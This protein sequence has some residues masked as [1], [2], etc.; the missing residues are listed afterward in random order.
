M[1]YD[2]FL[3]AP[4]NTGLQTDLRPWLIPDDA[5]QTLTNM[6]IF[7]GRLRKRFGSELMVGNTV[8][9][10]GTAQLYSRARLSVGTTNAS[11]NLSGTVPG[12][13]SVY[14]QIG[15]M[16][17][18]GNAIYTVNETGIA[19]PMLQTISTTTAT[20]D[21]TSGAFVFA[22]APASTTVYYYPAQPIMGIGQYLQG[23]FLSE[24]TYV[25]DTQFAYTWTGNGWAQLGAGSW[26]ITT[27]SNFQFFW[28]TTWRG[29]QTTS[30]IPLFFITNFNAPDKMQVWNGTTWTIFNP[31]Y[32][33][34]S[35]DNIITCRIILP[36]KGRLLLLNT[37]ESLSGTNTN[38]VNRCRFSAVGDPTATNAFRD[39]IPGNGGFV[40]AS[41]Y[42]QIVSAQI[43]KDRLIVFFEASTWELVYTNNQIVPFVWQKI[44]TELGSE[45][46]FSTIP[47]DKVALTVGNVGIH[48]CNGANVERIDEKIPDEVFDIHN[49]QDGPF[50]VYGIR[51]FETEMAYWTFPESTQQRDESNDE[52]VFPNRI[53]VYNYRTG[54]W[55]FN[56]DCITAFGYFLEQDLPD[57]LTWQLATNQWQE[58]DETWQ[59]G[60]LEAQT[61]RI[62]A[63]NQ[64]GF[65][66]LIDPDN[67]RN[68][69]AMQITNMI[70]NASVSSVTLTVINHNLADTDISQGTPY[71]I[72]IENCSGF[73]NLN[74]QIFAATMVADTNTFSIV[75]PA[76]I[77]PTGAY[78]GGGTIAIVSN[79]NIWSKQWN[80]YIDQGMNFYL[81]K[82]D[83]GVQR[84]EDGAV[85]V[86]YYPSS[87]TLSMLTEGTS[88]NT[89]MGTG[90]L[91]TSPYDPTIYPFEQVQDRLWHSVYFQTTGNSVQIRIYMSDSQMRDPDTTWNP[92]TI[93][94]L[95]LY[96]QPEGRLQ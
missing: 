46:T 36:F 63:G 81:A 96:T 86:D 56:S 32:D 3:I 22:G 85:T 15:Q 16:F 60:Y 48:A 82:I 71:Y 79:V 24:P 45:S 2:R 14:S 19:M 59:S 18:I 58:Y 17:S 13:S 73:T 9:A 40:D 54:A 5:F 28:T 95:V 7:R 92:F 90:V 11:G 61:V 23:S 1:P 33:G 94:G 76:P 35:G 74:G 84:T 55:A 89:I 10:T 47:F 6:Y 44:N 8:P 42:E 91:E 25:F 70:Y 37:V 38:F 50:R 57:G 41:T 12:A 68:S 43:L 26:T 87:S 21:T 69:P 20:F 83:F 62:I 78:T 39:D 29:P 80:P 88:T 30:N 93:E 52:I 66:F 51:D 77:T 4:L 75:L 65:L 27:G 72:A 64:Q 49:E 67:E 31:Q 34:T 53:L